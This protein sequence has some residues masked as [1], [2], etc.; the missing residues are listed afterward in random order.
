MPIRPAITLACI[1]PALVLSACGGADVGAG[2]TS[3]IHDTTAE[4]TGATTADATTEALPPGFRP[5]SSLRPSE[6]ASFGD[7]AMYTLGLRFE[8][9]PLL[10]IVREKESHL[11]VPTDP[12]SLVFI[13]SLALLYGECDPGA[14]G[15]CAPPLQ[16]DISPACRLNPSMY[17]GPADRH[18][19]RRTTIRGAPAD[20]FEDSVIIYSG[21]VAIK[22]HA[23]PMLA[24]RAAAALAPANDLAKAAIA[25][26]K[27][28]GELPAP[29]PGALDGTIAC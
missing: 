1:L 22:L 20:D 12:T 18:P 2:G 3:A 11:V 5:K 27:A 6:L 24:A 16:V 13:D 19:L 7:F 21:D 15:R 26:A 9:L 25:T 8:D 4:A 17:D 14:S 28:P 10:E 29:A 23:E